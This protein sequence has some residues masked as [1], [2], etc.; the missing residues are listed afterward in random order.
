MH[1][2]IISIEQTASLSLESTRQCACANHSAYL[3]SVLL[4]SLQTSDEQ[5]GSLHANLLSGAPEWVIYNNHFSLS[6]L[7][8]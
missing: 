3:I 6:P 7:A 5:L 4:P 8:W 2:I 1:V